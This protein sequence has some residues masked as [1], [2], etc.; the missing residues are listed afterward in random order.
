MT[1]KPIEIQRIDVTCDDDDTVLKLVT[2]IP[3][4]DENVWTLLFCRK[5]ASPADAAIVREFIQR[6][7]DAH[8]RR[9]YW[10]AYDAGVIEG[11]RRERS[12]RR[13]R[14]RAIRARAKGGE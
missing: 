3:A 4:T 5:S 9:A 14:Q 6:A 8:Y 11:Q 12:A 2:N 10:I 1:T 13:R 7:L